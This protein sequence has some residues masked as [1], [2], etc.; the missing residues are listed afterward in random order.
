[1]DFFKSDYFRET[2]YIKISS[3]LWATV[4]KKASAGQKKPP[5]RGLWTDINIISTILPYCS[6]IFVDD[7]CRAYL[8]EKP[9]SNEIEKYNTAV[10]SNKNRQEFFSYLDAIKSSAPKDHFGKVEE[11]YGHKW[12]KP[13]FELYM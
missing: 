3:M 2:P 7:A 10:F 12:S 1:M 6:A 9:L 11:V 8:A 13:F 4:A 5:N